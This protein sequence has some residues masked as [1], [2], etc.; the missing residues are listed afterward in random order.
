[1]KI[2]INGDDFGMTGSCSEAI[3]MAFDLGLITD[4]TM[5]ANGGYFDE[6]VGLARA[7][8]FFDKIG[9]HLNITE[10][11]PLTD[12]IKAFPDFVTDGRFNK[13]YDGSRALSD[14][15]A[16]AVY[17]ELT[18]QVVRVKDAGIAI[19][20]A[21]SH[22]Y[23][24]NMAE[25]MPVVT[26]VCREQGIDKLRLRMDIG[27]PEIDRDAADKYNKELR[28]LGFITTD[29]FARLRTF[30]PDSVEPDSDS[31]EPDSTKLDSDSVEPYTAEPDTIVELLAHPDLDRCGVLIDRTG[32][33]DGCPSG[34]DLKDLRE[35][36]SS[37]L[38]NYADL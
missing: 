8:G 22:H 37:P 28:E 12:G 3:A 5:V 17:T 21:D 29:H 4:T 1:M 35:R 10:G 27:V 19:T 33:T 6:A 18:A 32:M 24:H 2:I 26:R 31:I 23:V 13:S 38:T 36:I 16:E 11:E 7:K 14:G 15:E 9:V 20:H 25:I 30:D 34:D